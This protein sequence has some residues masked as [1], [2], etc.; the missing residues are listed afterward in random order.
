MLEVIEIFVY[1]DALLG[2]GAVKGLR[3]SLEHDIAH[4]ADEDEGDG[5][6]RAVGGQGVGDDGQQ[7]NAAYDIERTAGFTRFKFHCLPLYQCL[8]SCHVASIAYLQRR[9]ELV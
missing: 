6:D 3:V 9:F 1:D 8:R 7:E 5:H 2:D 4:D